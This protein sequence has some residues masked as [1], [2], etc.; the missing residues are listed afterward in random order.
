MNF[1]KHLFFTLILFC[2]SVPSYGQSFSAIENNIIY[3]FNV[4]TCDTI[5]IIH[6][7]VEVNGITYTPNGLLYGNNGNNGNLYLINQETGITD[8]VVNLGVSSVG[9]LVADNAGLIY[10]FGDNFLSYNLNTGTIQNYPTF[11][12]NAIGATYANGNIY[13]IVL[14]TGVFLLDQADPDN[15]T[16]LFP[17]PF[18]WDE[19]LLPQSLSFL[20]IT[21]DSSAFYI[22]YG[23]EFN[24]GLLH[25]LNIEEQ[26]T[27]ELPCSYGFLMG[28]SSSL[29]EYMTLSCEINLDL[30]NNNSSGAT[31]FDFL[32]DTTCASMGLLI[33]DEDI[34]ITSDGGGI[35][36]LI[37]FIEM[38]TAMEYV[39]IIG[40]TGI[41][42]QGNNS[43][44]LSLHNNGEA[45]LE[46]FATAVAQITYHNETIPFEEGVY[47]IAVL[48]WADG[49][50][51]DTAWACI[52]VFDL[53]LDA[54]EDNSLSVC[55][56]DPSVTLFDLLGSTAETGGTWFPVT[57]SNDGIFMPSVDEMGDYLYI[58]N[59]ANDCPADTASIVIEVFES[60]SFSFGNDTLLCGEESL[61]LTLNATG[62]SYFWQDGSTASTFVVETSGT[63]W[64]ELEN[65]NGCFFSDS[66]IVELVP[67]LETMEGVNL[68][69]GESFEYQNQTYTED[70]LITAHFTNV[71]GCDSIHNI[72]LS[73]STAIQV[74]TTV[75]ICEGDTYI[76]EDNTLTTD[77]LICETLMALNGCDSI[78][79]LNLSVKPSPTLDLGEE[80]SLPSGNTAIL[81]ATGQQYES[82][83]WSNGATTQAITITSA[84]IYRLT[85]SDENGCEAFDE[86]TITEGEEFVFFVPNVFTPNDDGVNDYFSI[87]AVPGRLNVV[88]LKIFDRWGEL[89]FNKSDFYAGIPSLGW[90]GK[91]KGQPM[92]SE[93]FV[94]LLEVRWMNGRKEIT[95]GEI[96]LLR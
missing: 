96:T 19:P 33:S 83:L 32:A 94:Y 50:V 51:S 1:K 65:E 41:S 67:I 13:F 90:D 66:I 16:L 34:E 10:Q 55:T 78:A 31:G 27:T 12:Y 91:F 15:S 7:N 2:F 58:Q 35:D 56:T 71:A 14:D 49:E 54:G 64:L 8:F 20:P 25:L 87:Y 82:Y 26:T 39:S 48:A 47:K 60:T 44:M 70:V 52:P 42:I 93:V 95:S 37:V 22:A 75:S 73:F 57:T 18:S 29:S 46:G 5:S 72:N 53:T 23:N 68:C 61:L 62:A 9:E 45:T 43:Q 80:F 6:P 3:N 28:S 76:F 63:Y 92:Q 36:S 81:S 59:G 11:P 74:T 17:I 86:V 21:C 88:N 24:E 84:G 30:D 40:Q 85:I 89:V 38:A 79:C 69:E 77:T 4:N